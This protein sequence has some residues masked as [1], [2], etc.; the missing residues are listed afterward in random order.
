MDDFK[1]GEYSPRWSLLEYMSNI[2]YK[3]GYARTLSCIWQYRVE[4]VLDSVSRS[5]HKYER[6]AA[7]V[8]MMT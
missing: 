3:F 4:L 6:R 8:S 5:P 7:V 1:M 2:M